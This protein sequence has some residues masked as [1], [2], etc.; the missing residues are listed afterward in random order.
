MVLSHPSFLLG[1]VFLPGLD[2]QD[3]LPSRRLSEHSQH[4]NTSFLSWEH[5]NTGG[6]H[7]SPAADVELR[8]VV[9][10]LLPSHGAAQG[11]G[12]ATANIPP[13]SK[14]LS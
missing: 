8:F 1:S 12:A 5:G 11:G 7:P 4:A 9:G 6:S 10:M 2:L 13:P 3:A 14:C